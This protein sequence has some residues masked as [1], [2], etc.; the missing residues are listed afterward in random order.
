MF[1]ALSRTAPWRNTIHDVT[2]WRARF[3]SADVH[4]LLGLMLSLSPY[5]WALDVLHML[6]YHGVSAHCT[7]NLLVDVIRDNELDCRTH[8]DTL[9]RC[10]VVDVE[11]N[12]VGFISGDEPL[13]TLPTWG[14]PNVISLNLDG[15]RPICGVPWQAPTS[16]LP[17]AHQKSTPQHTPPP[18]APPA[19]TPPHPPRPGGG[20]LQNF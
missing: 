13:P 19:T 1:V 4:P 6:D 10:R 7:G 14:L 12:P 9:D 20:G 3:Y 18:A 11:G 16:Q 15:T 8:G 5:S 17:E 2:S